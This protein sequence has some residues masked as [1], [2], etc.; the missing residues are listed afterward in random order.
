MY[1]KSFPQP[2]AMQ[3]CICSV[4]ARWC[5]TATSVSTVQTRIS[6][7]PCIT[8]TPTCTIILSWNVQ[9]W[10]NFS[11]FSS[12]VQKKHRGLLLSTAPLVSVSPLLLLCVKVCF[13][14][15][16]PSSHFYI[17][18]A[19]S[20]FVRSNFREQDLTLCIQFFKCSLDT[21]ST[22]KSCQIY[23][24]WHRVQITK[25]DDVNYYGFM[26]CIIWRYHRF[27]AV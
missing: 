2:K 4:W 13:E 11:F 3:I 19:R 23:F 5:T 26:D 14:S 15:L 18:F 20:S 6:W 21:I 17:R 10:C 8:A 16:P 9:T 1:L 22:I 27:F 7:K 12:M 25:L 24:D